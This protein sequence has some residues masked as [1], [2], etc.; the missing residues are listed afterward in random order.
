MDYSNQ[1]QGDWYHGH[2]N[3]YN[4]GVPAYPNQTPTYGT[5]TVYGYQ[6]DV[7]ATEPHQ[8]GQAFPVAHHQF[9]TQQWQ[10]QNPTW[11]QGHLQ[12]VNLQQNY[13]YGATNHWSQYHCQQYSQQEVTRCQP[14]VRDTMGHRHNATNDGQ[15]QSQ[16]QQTPAQA[17][18]WVQPP[19]KTPT[20]DEIIAMILSDLQEE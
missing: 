19:A 7:P 5:P 17:Q 3:G 18:A 10:Q 6:Y 11:D 4:W 15:S 12:P 14:S 1:H 16:Y 8:V 13:N 20:E 9:Q 2:A